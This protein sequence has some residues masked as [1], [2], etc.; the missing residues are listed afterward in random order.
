M[1]FQYDKDQT[2]ESLKNYS[3]DYQSPGIRYDSLVECAEGA[4]ITKSPRMRENLQAR[5][6]D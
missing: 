2:P 4:N 6:D 5:S 1:Y 3:A